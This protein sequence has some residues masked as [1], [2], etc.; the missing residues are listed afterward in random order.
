MKVLE[1]EGNVNYSAQA[2]SRNT[3]LDKYWVLGRPK[4]MQL[5]TTWSLC[6]DSGLFLGKCFSQIFHIFPKDIFGKIGKNLGKTG[7]M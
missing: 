7:R 1:C 2:V 4:S 5:I 3:Y 6:K